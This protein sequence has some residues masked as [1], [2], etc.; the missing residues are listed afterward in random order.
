[1]SRDAVQ[2]RTLRVLVLAQ[3][4]GGAGLAAGVSVGALLAKEVLG[5]TSGAGLPAALFTAGSAGAAFVVGN[6]SH[7]HGRRVGLAAGYLAGAAG[8]AGVVVAA[9]TSNV[10]LL[11]VSLLVYGSGTATS[12]QCRYAGADLA[13]EHERG[14]AVST[15][16]VATTFGA[17][18]GPNLLGVTGDLAVQADMPRLAGPFVLASLSYALA[19][20]VLAALL[21]P[22]PL[23]YARR[24]AAA[25]AEG[26]D[27]EPVPVVEHDPT[28][29]VEPP[30]TD[31]L[32]P[33]R[34][35]ALPLA[36]SGMVL[37]QAVMVAVMSMTPVH[38]RDH[39]HGLGIVGIV[40]GVH[41]AF[42]YLPSPLTGRLVDRVGP[43]PVVGAGGAVLLAAGLIAAVAP[44]SAAGGLAI[45]LALLGLGWNLTLVG[46]T[47]MVT[48]LTTL[49]RRA[50][51]QG[52]VDLTVALAGA[53]G[54][55]AS[56]AILASTSFQV[57]ALTAAG[58]ALLVIPA[59]TTSGR[60]VR[61][62]AA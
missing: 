7:R 33:R 46:G 2:R 58:L 34:D 35:L 59:A 38:L 29:A 41:I 3:V 47:A 40:I 20:I 12:L 60:S 6:L 61:P 23:L 44:A 62:A 45:A 30:A 51:T 26:V 10:P 16:L 18:A 8:G 36:A 27:D 57:L 22:D 39:D 54:G 13:H 11:L 4:F 9:V 14:K 53:A 48:N 50:R 37:A 55:L 24:L 49:E 21:R 1:M 42:M 56:G 25:P 19:G 52:T 28:I 43:A 17:V 5:S 31:L 32:R 15:V